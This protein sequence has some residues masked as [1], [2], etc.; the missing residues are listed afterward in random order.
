ME[1]LTKMRLTQMRLVVQWKER[2]CAVVAQKRREVQMAKMILLR[3]RN[4]QLKSDDKKP[5]ASTAAPS[6]SNDGSDKDE[7]DWAVETKKEERQ[8]R[9]V[10]GRRPEAADAYDAR[11]A[12]SLRGP[13][14]RPAQGHAAPS[15]CLFLCGAQAIPTGRRPGAATKRVSVHFDDD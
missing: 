2:V 4:E 15:V 10:E 11:A 7:S 5:Q 9:E 6:A 13:P 12:R 1:T 8:R 14:R 3:K